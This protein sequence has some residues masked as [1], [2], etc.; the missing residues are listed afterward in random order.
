MVKNTTK[1][2]IEF[3]Y[4]FTRSMLARTLPFLGMESVIAIWTSVDAVLLS[5]LSNEFSLGLYNASAQLLVPAVLVIENLAFSIFP[6]MCRKFDAGMENLKHVYEYL[7]EALLAI[8]LPAAVGLSF[9]AQPILLLLY[10]GD[11]FA[12]GDIV[13]QTLVWILIPI[14]LTKALGQVLMASMQ[15]TLT[16]KIVIINMI[17]SIV[18]GVLFIIPMGVFGAALSTVVS[19]A[20]NL[21]Q[22]YF[23][24]TKTLRGINLWQSFWKPMAATL[25]M[26]GYLFL[27]SHMSIWFVIPTAALIYVICLVAILI[28]SSGGIALFREK[29]FLT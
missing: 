12:Q 18:L 23:P 7:I 10:G 4:N 14:A 16:L 29:Y 9:L 25:V 6:L 11:N 22:H 17:I 28:L 5:K 2:H 21:L 20:I 24:A 15:E 1:L 19:Q 26:A 3:D 27:V 8:A 13:L